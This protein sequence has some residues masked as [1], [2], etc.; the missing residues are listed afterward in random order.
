MKDTCSVLCTNVLVSLVP[1]ALAAV[2]TALILL[3]HW[4]LALT[5]DS[6]RRS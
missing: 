6:N 3:A 4:M 5:S 2:T 1:L